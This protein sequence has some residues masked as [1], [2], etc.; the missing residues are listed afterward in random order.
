MSLAFNAT[1]HAINHEDDVVCQVLLYR[2]EAKN[3]II[4]VVQ[5][6]QISED[7]PEIQH[8]QDQEPKAMISRISRQT[9]QQQDRRDHQT[10]RAT[11]PDTRDE[12]EPPTVLNVSVFSRINCIRRFDGIHVCVPILLSCIPYLTSG[13]AEFEAIS[14]IA[15]RLFIF[16]TYIWTLHFTVGMGYVCLANKPHYFD[17]MSDGGSMLFKYLTI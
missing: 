7:L 1:Q 15:V 17:V 9:K 14:H 2:T 16:L 8:F 6:P 11:R 10:S 4:K 5:Q 3:I 13:A 12:P